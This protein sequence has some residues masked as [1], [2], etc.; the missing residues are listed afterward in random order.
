MSESEPD[1]LLG[2][3]AALRARARRDRRATSTPLLTLAGI[4]LAMA[5]LP[6]AGLRLPSSYAWVLAGPLVFAVS[7]TALRQREHREGIGSPAGSY[8]LTAIVL[9]VVLLVGF[10]LATAFGAAM[11]AV[12][13]ALLVLA[14]RQRAVVLGTVAVA[15]G[16][17]GVLQ[18][19]FV[20]SNAVWRLTG[21]DVSDRAIIGTLGLAVL[22]VAVA[23]RVREA[24]PA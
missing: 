9:L 8:R 11:A 21:A 5:M 24:V 6:G 3:L 4:T 19:L 10:P 22:V 15:Y 12:A 13:V 17:V 20:I 1:D 2:G 23:V 14:I 7:A 16:A 18:S